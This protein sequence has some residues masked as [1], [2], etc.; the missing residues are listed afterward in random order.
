M[1]QYTNAIGD[2]KNSSLE[3]V[4]KYAIE[5][6]RPKISYFIDELLPVIRVLTEVFQAEERFI[7]AGKIMGT[8]DLSQSRAITKEQKAEWYITAARFFISGKDT[9]SAVSFVNLALRYDY[10]KVRI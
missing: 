10:K 8:V 6:L 4:A 7:E 5:Q 3:V 2:L 9:V 1:K